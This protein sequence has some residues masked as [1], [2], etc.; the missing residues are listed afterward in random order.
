MISETR[1]VHPKKYLYRLL[2][3]LAGKLYLEHKTSVMP[4][5]EISVP[6]E[7]FGDF[8][9]NLAMR[10]AKIMAEDPKTIAENFANRIK[11]MDTENYFDII[12]P[13]GGFVNFKLSKTYLLKNLQNILQQGELYG[14][15]LSG[16]G[17]T[18]IV[19]YFQNNVAKPPHVGHLRSAV[20]G[21]CL[22]RIFRSQGYKAISDTHIGDW[23]VQFGIL[24]YAYKE[25]IKGGGKKEEIEKDPIN[26]LNK[27]YV[28]L[29]AK[30]EAD[31]ALREKGKEEFIKLEK[32]NAENRELWQ[33]FVR[34][35]LED[36]ET[37]RKLL[38]V[39]PFDHNLG[40]SFYE[41]KMPK[42][43]EELKNKHLVKTGETGEQYVDLEEQGLGRC[44][45]VK[46]DGG[47]TYHLRDFAT[48]IYRKEQFNF[49]KNI[50]VVDNRQSHH[51]AQL[52]KVLEL[53]GYPT[54]DDSQHVDLGFMSLPEGAIST[55][56]GT[57]ISLQNLINEA[58]SR[59]LK[60]IEDKNPDLPNKVAISQQVALAAIKYFDLSH[61]RKSEIIFTWDKALSF[62]GNTGPYLQYTHARI[63]GILRKGSRFEVTGSSLTPNTLHLAPPELSILRKLVQFPEIVS[64]V[65]QDYFP[66]NLCIYLFELSQSFNSF[67][68][69]ISVLQEKDEKLK[70]FRLALITATAQVISNGLY[71]LGIEAPEEM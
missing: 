17:K 70:T 61:N 44:I 60:I 3:D 26:E 54:I 25:F 38:D 67:Y 42:V 24:I 35:S 30:I 65:T 33:W 51:F 50:Y 32:G 49:L 1:N 48:Y 22:L 37:Y 28:E 64:Q 23:G 34:V 58:R 71:L 47:T 56:K 5:V 6:E 55:R 4:S 7:K 53:A 2:S 27:L 31:A 11:A 66:N 52:F 39:L 68:Q 46:S 63:H 40:E 43:L 41:D 15:S 13:M 45:L 18:V 59:A 14:C 19:E 36:F 12:E 16:E 62:E 29:S 69:E 57:I 9:T 21:D 10:F 20:I 8:S